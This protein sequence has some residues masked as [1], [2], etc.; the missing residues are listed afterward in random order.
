[1]TKN[2]VLRPPDPKTSR[3][4]LDELTPRAARVAMSLETF[5]GLRV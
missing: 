2:P 3:L 5:V 4:C 1:M